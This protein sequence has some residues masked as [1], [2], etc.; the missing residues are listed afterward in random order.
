[1]SLIN[2][3]AA[4]FTPSENDGNMWLVDMISSVVNPFLTTYAPSVMI[5][6]TINKAVFGRNSPIIGQETA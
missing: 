3:W 1:M 2:D 4:S 6:E 5:K